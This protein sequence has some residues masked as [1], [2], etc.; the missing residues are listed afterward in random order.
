MTESPLLISLNTTSAAV[1]Q[2]SPAPWRDELAARLL[3]EPLVPQHKS[4]SEESG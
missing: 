3:R 1:V 2:A 4:E